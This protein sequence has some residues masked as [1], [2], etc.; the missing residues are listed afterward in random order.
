M[1]SFW[2]SHH[3]LIERSDHN[4]FYQNPRKFLRSSPSDLSVPN[5]SAPHQVEGG[6]SKFNNHKFHLHLRLPTNLLASSLQHPEREAC[7][8]GT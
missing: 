5:L 7:T 2:N 4:P 3:N 6:V 1:I 8:G